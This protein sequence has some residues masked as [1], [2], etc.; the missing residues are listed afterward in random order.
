MDG[1]DGRV[2]LRKKDLVDALGVAKSTVADWVG[3]FQVFIPTSKEGSLTYY[4]PEAIDVLNTI[5]AL[6]EQNMPKGEIYAVLQDKGFPIT[7]Q[8]AI[9][10]VQKALAKGDARKQLLDVMGQVGNALERLADQEETLEYI[11]KRQ[12]HLSDQQNSLSEQQSVQDGR[13]TDLEL[14]VQQLKT[15][16]ESARTEIAITK[17]E[18]EKKRKPWW[19]FGR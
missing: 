6:R 18:L 14:T 11:E 10:D 12:N 4:M 7:V 8:E 15:E 9:E 3:E 2:L 17:A 16:L 19:R 5:K 1:T 13:V